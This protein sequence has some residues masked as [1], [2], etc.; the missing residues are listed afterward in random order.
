MTEGPVK[1]APQLWG[2]A[3]AGG[4]WLV[5]LGVSLGPIGLS[6]AGAILV[7][8]VVGGVVALI[9]GL[10]RETAP[11]AVPGSAG[12]ATVPEAAPAPAPSPAPV[13]AAAPVAVAAAPAEPVAAA[14]PQGLSAPRGGAPDDLKLIK[15]IGPAL[16]KLCH[17]LGYYHFDQI[18]AWTPAE[19]AWVDDNLEGFK[20]RVTRDNWV[21]QAKVLAAGRAPA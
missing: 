8:T 14:R 1:N 10:P 5:A 16:E 20:G 7:A 2:L 21:A 12:V 9:L 6:S 19:V 3:I 17:S 4:V 18:A 11:P 13:P 15:G